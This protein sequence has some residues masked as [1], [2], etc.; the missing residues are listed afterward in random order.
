MYC[1]YVASYSAVQIMGQGSS[2]LA[3][4]DN[5]LYTYVSLT[6]HVL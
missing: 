1:I 5:K 3:I 2:E 6:V 4:H